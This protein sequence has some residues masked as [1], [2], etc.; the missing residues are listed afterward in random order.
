MGLGKTLQTIS[1]LAYLA[2]FKGIWGPH[3]I[4]VPT[5][6]IVN[7]ETEF[8]RFCPGFKVSLPCH[9]RAC[10]MLTRG[11][12]SLPTVQVLTYYGSAKVRRELRTGWTKPNSF[13]VC[14]TS[15]QLAVQDASSFKR[16][17]WYHLILDEAHNIKNFK[18]QRW[19]T[20]LTFS[21]QRRLLLTGTPLQNNLMEL[22]SL[23]HF[24]MPHVFRSRKEFS[25][26]FSQPLTGMVEGSRS[27]S[28]DL[29]GR[30]HSVMRPF[31]LRRLKKE[32]ERELPG[33]FEHIVMCQLSRR[34]QQLY[35]EFMSR[36]ST[37]SALGG[38]NFMGM[39]NVLMQLRKV[40]NHPDLFEPRL[41]DTPFA[42]APLALQ[43]PCIVAGL[44][45]D[46]WELPREL[47][48]PLWREY[49]FSTGWGLCEPDRDLLRRLETP[50]DNISA[51]WVDDVGLPPP[52][53]SRLSIFA[54]YDQEMEILSPEVIHALAAQRNTLADELEG[55][56]QLMA[57]VN[58]RRCGPISSSEAHPM[59]WRL[60]MAV[61]V[62]VATDITTLRTDWAHQPSP[63]FVD[64]L[65]GVG[66]QSRLWKPLLERFC[67]LVPPVLVA[68]PL[69]LLGSG[70]EL[71]EIPNFLARYPLSANPDT[72]SALYTAASR[73]L[74]CFADRRLVQ[75]DA[76]KLRTLAELLRN[77]KAGGHKVLIFTQMSKMLD[78]LEVFLNLG[79]HTYVRLDG[80][81]GV[82][83][84][85]HLMDKFNRDP[86]I[87][88]FILSTRS[89]G[90]GINLTAADSVIFYDSDWNPAMDAQ[91]QDRAHRIG[92]TREVH[93]FRFVTSGTIEENI[94]IKAQQKRH[95]DHLV[96][97]EGNFDAE[98]VTTAANYLSS[99]GLRDILG[100]DQEEG[101]GEGG[102]GELSGKAAEDAMATLE[103]DEDVAAGRALLKE[104]AEEAQ[105]FSDEPVP[106]SAA[107]SP[108]CTGEG[109]KAVVNT[110]AEADKTDE[111]LEREFAAWQGAIGPDIEALEAALLPIERFG[112]QFRTHIDPFYSIFYRTDAQRR[113][114]LEAAQGQHQVD[115]EAIDA[116]KAEE[117]RRQAST[118]IAGSA[119]R[120]ALHFIH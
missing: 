51:V 1:L 110:E 23:M 108:E 115:V 29:I 6:C 109:E 47:L 92:Q 4:I 49:H 16:K 48:Q 91:A 79:G 13:N 71:A 2:C 69:L 61:S 90:L 99:G 60:L 78:I 111:Q 10:Q 113:E 41:I 120:S 106:A 40:C 89:G 76:G 17:K 64:M 58:Q 87:F 105:E 24:L 37:R 100:A 97:T 9:H 35:E 56:R 80:S 55:R 34:Q 20:L 21:S 32:V 43:L 96:M 57:V 86:R 8:K 84:R 117:E 5:S 38:G 75:Y 77:L 83:K 68:P 95:L 28:S 45:R 65:S 54:G 25:Y 102:E 98:T 82:E 53:P 63:S 118:C 103:D 3:L 114:E 85:Q 74:L 81:T 116:E 15:Y 39:M 50:S 88:C 112:L 62:Q 101:R 59:N 93:I 22:W 26:W 11:I 31:L 46:R 7:W 18:S 94:L 12:A 52:P 104:A 107:D 70:G 119:H 33:K 72:A 30:L 44:T 36:S 27:I 66:R 73:K 14:I 42:Q 67:C 19:Q